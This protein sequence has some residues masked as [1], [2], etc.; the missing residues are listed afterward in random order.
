MLGGNLQLFCLGVNLVEKIIGNDRLQ[1][2]NKPRRGLLPAAILDPPSC[3][4]Y[5][6][7]KK[8]DS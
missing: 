7:K 2:G 6:F 1:K 8:E 3:I 4:S 5:F